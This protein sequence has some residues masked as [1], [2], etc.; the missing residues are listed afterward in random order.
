LAELLSNENLKPSEDLAR[1]V[2]EEILIGLARIHDGL[3][4]A[5]GAVNPKNIGM[6]SSD[7]FFLWSTPT[8]WLESVRTPA[9]DMDPLWE[10]PY[11]AIEVTESALP[12]VGMDIFAVGRV[13]HELLP[14]NLRDACREAMMN[15][16]F[17]AP[18]NRQS[19]S[20][21]DSVL[22]SQKALSSHRYQSALEM[23]RAVNPETQLARLRIKDGRESLKDGLQQYL[24]GRYEQAEELWQDGLKQDWLS[25]ALWNNLAIC[26]MRRQE[27]EEA[28]FDLLKAHSMDPSHSVVGCNL[29][30]CYICLGRL[31][32]AET[33]ARQTET[34]RPDFIPGLIVRSNL[35]L[36]LKDYDTAL[37][38]ATT[39]MWKAPKDRSAR[40][41]YLRILEMMDRIP[42]AETKREELKHFPYR[43]PF[44]DFLVGDSCLPAWG[45]VRVDR[46][47]SDE[48]PPDTDGSG[49]PKSP[50]V[51]SPRARGEIPRSDY[52]RGFPS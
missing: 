35:A 42:E 44:A 31:D 17:E 19:K 48:E 2:A 40:W 20:L 22:N 3:G 23:A 12:E 18:E 16:V 30:F 1:S 24:L 51:P 33:W 36:K 45:N 28:V 34:M 26:K 29:G 49:V 46:G 5:H 39:A 9:S 14:S 21:V 32:Q 4:K 6:D 52:L 13:I 37:C 27:W 50:I 43:V 41:Q 7:S 8:C 47:R 15:S 11:R 10:I 25:L 38:Y